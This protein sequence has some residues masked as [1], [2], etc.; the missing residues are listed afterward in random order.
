MQSPRERWPT[1]LFLRVA[2]FS[3][4]I[5]GSIHADA[6]GALRAQMSRP[7]P[8]A[9]RARWRDSRTT[10]YIVT[11]F[12][13][14]ERHF[15]IS[16]YCGHDMLSPALPRFYR[17]EVQRLVSCCRRRSRHARDEQRASGRLPRSAT[18]ANIGAPIHS[19]AHYIAG[20]S[21]RSR[22]HGAARRR[23]PAEGRGARSRCLTRSRKAASPSALDGA[24]EVKPQGWRPLAR[25]QL[26]RR[27]A[28]ASSRKPCC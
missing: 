28:K 5:R 15:A 3:H 27:Q 18:M 20:V 22:R 4:F 23:R 16:R 6:S 25:G 21:S 11:R 10:L 13:I 17:A 9:W 7:S 1:S 2:D 19:T 14:R 12:L 26:P 8:A 24:F